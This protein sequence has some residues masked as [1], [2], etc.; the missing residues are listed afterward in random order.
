MQ[1]R[2]QKDALR[3]STFLCSTKGFSISLASY[4]RAC[5]RAATS[6]TANIMAMRALTHLKSRRMELRASLGLSL[7]FVG[8]LGDLQMPAQQWH[9]LVPP[10]CGVYLPEAMEGAQAAASQLLGPHSE[11]RRFLFAACSHAE[12]QMACT[13]LAL[14]LGVT[15]RAFAGPCMH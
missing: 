1:V 2:I 10:A 5:S 6:D 13:A 14:M 7:A 15:G 8:P 11:N 9:P 12:G 4:R 3:Y